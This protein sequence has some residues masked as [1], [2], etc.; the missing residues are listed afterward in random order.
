M[1]VELRNLKDSVVAITGASSGIGRESSRLLAEAGARLVLGARRTERLDALVDELGDDRVIGVALDVRDP[2]SCRRFVAAG[3]EKF[4]RIDSLVASAGVGMYGGVDE[5]DDE[6]V[7]EM[8]EVNVSGTV[9]SVRAALPALRDAGGG[10]VVIIASVAGLRG[11]ANEPVYAATKFAQVGLAG[12]M[13]RQLLPEGIRVTAICPAGVNTEFA[14]GHG[15]VPGDPSLDSLLRA[16]DVAF[17]VVTVL[18]QP[19]RLRTTMWSMWSAAES[20]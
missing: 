4:G 10:D 19:R 6:E 1:A 2:D 20:S 14:L 9:W 13:D 15:R 18:R 3:V 8:I 11:G 5:L 7:T 16:E 12:A 17:Q